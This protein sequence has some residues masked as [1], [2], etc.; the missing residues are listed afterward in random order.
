MTDETVSMED[1]IRAALVADDEKRKEAL[2]I[3]RDGPARSCPVTTGPLLL[4]VG[5]AAELLGVSRTTLWRM[6]REGRLEGVEIRRGSYRVRRA[7]L[8]K[9]VDGR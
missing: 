2:R 4:R 5:A 8:H 3:L 7:D 9:L 6:M 1:F